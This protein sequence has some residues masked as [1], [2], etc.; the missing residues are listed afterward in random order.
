M[1]NTGLSSAKF[2]RAVHRSDDA[3]LT[4]SGQPASI[5]PLGFRRLGPSPQTWHELWNDF[6][7]LASLGVCAWFLAEMLIQQLR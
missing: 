4:D 3:A 1:N 7:T 6:L 5:K 2:N